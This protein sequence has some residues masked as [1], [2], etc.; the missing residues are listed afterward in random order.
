MP[1]LCRYQ[2]T[3]RKESVGRRT[4]GQ[5]VPPVTENGSRN[6][7]AKCFDGGAPAVRDEKSNAPSG[8]SSVSAADIAGLDKV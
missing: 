7:P 5:V 8:R 2:F 3:K 4:F 1:L 6:L